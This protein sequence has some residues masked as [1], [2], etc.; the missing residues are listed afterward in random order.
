MELRSGYETV[1]KKA[2]AN[3]NKNVLQH[4]PERVC[5]SAHIGSH[6]GQAPRLRNSKL[7]DYGVQDVQIYDE[8]ENH[9]TNI[10]HMS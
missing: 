5:P 7:V 3:N 2:S 6:K 10:V 8:D 1:Y 4:G 9:H